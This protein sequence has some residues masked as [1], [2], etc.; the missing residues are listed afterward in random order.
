MLPQFGITGKGLP[1]HQHSSTGKNKEQKNN[2]STLFFKQLNGTKSTPKFTDT[3]SQ[4][5]MINKTTSNC[6]T[7]NML[8]KFTQKTCIPWIHL[9]YNHLN[10]SNWIKLLSNLATFISNSS[11][12]RMG[13]RNAGSFLVGINIFF[14]PDIRHHTLHFDVIMVT[15]SGKMKKKSI[16]SATVHTTQSQILPCSAIL[17]S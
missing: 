9:S 17:L 5:K 15:N 3:I 16:W 11:S 10:T 6:M 2:G 14:A 4:L 7:G 13:S 12:V 1:W 8:Q